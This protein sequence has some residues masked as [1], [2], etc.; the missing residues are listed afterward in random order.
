MK[1]EIIQKINLL[2]EMSGAIGSYESLAEELKTVS[3][4]IEHQKDVVRD[5]KKAISDN[6]YINSN[7]KLID[8]NIK[9]GLENRIKNLNERLKEVQKQID[10]VAVEEESLHSAVES[11]E[12]ELEQLKSLLASL[13]LKMKTTGSKKQESY[14]FYERMI[15]KTNHDI[16][17]TSKELM[18]KR[19]KYQQVS[20]KLERLGD[21]REVLEKKL[22]KEQERLEEINTSLLN[23]NSYVDQKRKE[24]DEK[25]VDQLMETLEALERHRLEILTNPIYIGHE[26]EQFVLQEDH[27]SALE[28]IKEMVTIVNAMPYMDSRNQ[29]LPELL[30]NA[31]TRRD[32]FANSIEEKKYNGKN[33]KAIELRVAYLTKK[34]ERIENQISNYRTLVTQ[35]D[36]E[37]IND[38][39][40]YVETAKE[41][42]NE[43]QKEI[44]EYHH[45]IDS[46]KEYLTPRK[47][48]TLHTALKQKEEELKQLTELWDAFE[49]DLEDTVIT[50]KNM[51]EQQISDLEQEKVKI[52]EELNKLKEQEH[53]NDSSKD[54]LAIQQDKEKL[55][56]LNDEVEKILHRQKYTETP[57]EIFDEIE[58]SFSSNEPEQAIKRELKSEDYVDLNDYRITPE[59]ELDL[60]VPVDQEKEEENEKIIP[61]PVEI[62]KPEEI[63]IFPEEETILTF[64]PRKAKEPADSNLLK[65]VN[66]EPLEETTIQKEPEPVQPAEEPKSEKPD[67]LPEDNFMINDFEDTD[68]ISFNDLL[69]EA[70]ND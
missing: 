53:P 11:L 26:A 2:I 44:K 19:E 8:E 41:E 1:N 3:E 62:E 57:S 49:K 29:D 27:T 17:K 33:S 31:T 55:K 64:P 63:A 70:S 12:K 50:S 69:E 20:K 58:L 36:N 42:K 46:S 34:L 10:E 59:P 45:V 56:S 25:N 6:T 16:E 65:V 67:S 32:E 35:L 37:V 28:K 47:K 22:A 60:E 7:E 5:L 4:E 15:E 68:Y 54:I 52:K 13:D 51:E 61:E 30:E 66:I 43:L 14:S 23:S 38:L 39:A 18:E 48:A 24:Q 21:T 40:A 9:L